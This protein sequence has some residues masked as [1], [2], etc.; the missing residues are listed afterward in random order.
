LD[1]TC[2]QE[3]RVFTKKCTAEGTLR[4]SNWVSRWY[5]LHFQDCGENCASQRLFFAVD[6]KLRSLQSENVDELSIYYVLQIQNL[7]FSKE[8]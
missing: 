3:C 4:C 1:S 6:K 5:K 2:K 7:E 8:A